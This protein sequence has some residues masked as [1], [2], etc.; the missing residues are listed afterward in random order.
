M[1]V[2]VLLFPAYVIFHG[3]GEQT[4]WCWGCEK[5]NIANPVWNNQSNPD[6]KI[7]WIVCELISCKC[8]S[9][10]ILFDVAM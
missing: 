3:S 2:P 5:F 10:F 1:F 6:Q 8:L 9:V 4:M 7:V